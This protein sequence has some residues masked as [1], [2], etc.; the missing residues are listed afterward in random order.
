[1]PMIHQWRLA[2]AGSLAAM[3]LAGPGAAVAY[4]E[5]TVENGGTVAGRI[6]FPGEHPESESFKVP[7][8]NHVCGIRKRD[9]T[10]IVDGTSGGLKNAVI[11]IVGVSAG[12]PLALPGPTLDQA[13]CTYVPH[14]QVA[15]LGTQVVITNSDPIL[16]NIHAWVGDKTLFNVAQPPVGKLQFRQDLAEVGPVRVVCDVHDWMAAYVYVVDHPY[17]AVTDAAGR[18]TI[19]D[20]P[21][22]TYTLKV[23]HEGLG[24]VTREV[25]VT[26]GDTATEDFEIGK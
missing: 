7:K 21:P 5:A 2:C 3:L 18:F 16:H 14:L 26:A 15:A 13:E 22:G 10:F 17:V 19:P 24:E 9:Q 23:W 12:K 4:E 1:M 25:T 8:D 11:E 20:V 6:W